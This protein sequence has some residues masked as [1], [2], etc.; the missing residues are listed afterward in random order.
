MIGTLWAAVLLSGCG[1]KAARIE[2]PANFTGNVRIEC[3]TTGDSLQGVQ[4]DASGSGTA[5]VCP[6]TDERVEIFRAGKVTTPTEPI[7]WLRTGDGFATQL[8][9]AVK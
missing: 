7:K 9:F 1:P 6:K 5:K 3:K 8:R 2:L 4:V